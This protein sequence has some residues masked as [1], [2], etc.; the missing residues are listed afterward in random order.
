M[1]SVILFA[2]KLRTLW[3][4]I[5]P[6]LLLIPSIIYN[7]DTDAK[8]FSMMNANLKLY[9]LIII[10]IAVILFMLVYFFRLVRINV[11]EI[12]CIGPF[13]SRSRV[14]LKKERSLV[15]TLLKHGRIRIEVF[16]ICADNDTYFWLK[17]EDFTEINLFRAKANGKARTVKK[18]LNFFGV[19]EDKAVKS[20]TECGQI[21]DTKDFTLSSD[22]LDGRRAIRLYFKE[23]I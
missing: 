6:V 8:L 5:P 10:L 3:V 1:K 18:I 7:D 9:P 23:T 22:I 14:E 11:E 19:D 13:S 20:L 15:L 4:F 12:R 17:E 16:G 2:T 21:E